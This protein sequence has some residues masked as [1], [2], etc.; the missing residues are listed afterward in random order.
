MAANQQLPGTFYVANGQIIGPNG[1]PFIAKGI[2]LFDYQT[3]AMGDAAGSTITSAFPGINMVRLAVQ[4]FASAAALT[5]YVNQ[6]TSRGIVVEIED[7]SAPFGSNNVL[8][9]SALS[10]EL[11]WY[12]S[13][14]S[15]FKSNPYVWFGTMNEPDNVGNE[16]A[17]SNQEVSIYNTIRSAGNT[18]PI[19][20][21]QIAGYTD[22]KNG[23]GLTASAYASM[24]NIIWDTHIYG[25]ESNFS[26]DPAAIS[27]ALKAQV[28]NAQGI[29]SA[30]GVIPVI[31]GEYGIS[32][33]GYGAAD[34]NGTQLVS[35]VDASGYGSLAWAWSAG[36]D[37]LVN[38]DG[39]L[40]SF[41]TQIA[42]YLGTAAPPPPPPPPPFNGVSSANNTIV[43]GT[44]AA[45]TDA[46]G[47]K[48][49]ITAGGQVAINGAADTTTTGVKELAYVNGTIW[50]EN[51][52]NLWW[53]EAKPN[54]SWAPA[55][56]TL[57]SPLPVVAPPPPASPDN[58]IVK[59]GSAA[60][61]VDASGNKWTITAGGQVAVGGVADTTTAGV[62]ELAYE[63]GLIWQENAGG[64]WWSKT[65]TSAAW[66][67]AAG[68]T[69][70]PVPVPVIQSTDNTVVKVGSTAA[71]TDAAGNKWTITTG[72]QVAVNGVA[73]T[74]TSGVAELAYEKGL[75]WQENAGGMWWS[76]ASTT[77][78]W[79]PAAG[80]AVSPVPVVAT[81]DNTVVLAGSAAAI[82]DA[83][84]NKWTITAAGQVAVNG[85]ADTTT[86]GVAE[87][88]YTKG[89]IWQ[90]N[91]SSLWWSKTAPGA[92]WGP[93]AG[94]TTAPI[95][96]TVTNTA[97]AAV[98]TIDAT[99]VHNETDYGATFSLT[100]P[101]AAKVT[102]GATSETLAFAHMS[103][104]SLTAGSTAATVVTD[105]GTN[106]FT[107]G[108]GTLDVKGG[109]GADGY[110]YHSGNA[111]LTVEDFSL[112][113]AD[114]LTIDKALTGSLVSASD[115]HGGTMLS[116]GSPGAGLDLKAVAA[117]PTANIHW[118]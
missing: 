58:T 69:I 64:L 41:G 116:F 68:T 112:A 16:S 91:A 92:A 21:E 54:A 9:G 42:K 14:A 28:A 107:A 65:S 87:L 70:S 89:L 45:I 117:M 19:M 13:M 95:S 110:I 75:I 61:I 109:T 86:S 8:S 57:T 40:D 5:S 30:D 18:N 55:A 111:L 4:N 2:N 96:I 77:A 84:G 51:G 23:D 118:V 82:T 15:A 35:A 71:I 81:P 83:T 38:S 56:G 44:T 79:G 66:G 12:S 29:T 67:P 43:T 115:G 113:K 106:S 73:D 20:M 22:N 108:K 59:V 47:N 48:W 39:S 94:T 1:S 17:V 50:Q 31:I 85:V 114:S 102:L 72:G 10:N 37:S 63:K 7:H 101:G 32:S 25:W 74:T 90:E 3:T 76:K 99:K 98:T 100:A 78:A 33:T 97:T 46:S 34:P 36:T 49:T 27:A 24:S 105:G 11:A 52:S 60:A 104:I 88:D 80:T 62:T 6:M 93:A 53:G 103:S 26:T